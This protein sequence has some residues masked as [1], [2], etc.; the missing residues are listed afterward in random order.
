MGSRGRGTFGM[1]ESAGVDKAAL[2]SFKSHFIPPIPTRVEINR[3]LLRLFGAFMMVVMFCAAHL[4]PAL[5]FHTETSFCWEMSPEKSLPAS[6]WL[7]TLG[8]SSGATPGSSGMAGMARWVQPWLAALARGSGVWNQQK[9]LQR[10]HWKIQD[11]QIQ[12]LCIQY[13]QIQHY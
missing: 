4:A 8:K 11:C 10:G 13:Y 5:H 12:C 3:V 2:H 6:K 1:K 7:Q 9:E